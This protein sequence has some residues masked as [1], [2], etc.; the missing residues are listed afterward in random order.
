MKRFC[1]ILIA[2]VVLATASGLHATTVVPPTFDQ[3]VRDAE[4][5]FEGKVTSTKSQWEGEGSERNIFTYVTFDVEDALKGSLGAT[6]T[7]KML[8]GTVGGE[9][10]AVADGPK[11]KE[12][13][14]DVLFVEHNGAQFIPL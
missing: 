12:G 3:L 11:F 4:F 6:F 1:S 2:V 7:M 8:G 13:D 14:R 10:A 9:S 5:V